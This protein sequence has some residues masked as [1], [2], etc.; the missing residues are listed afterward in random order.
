MDYQ[1]V[2]NHFEKELEISEFLLA[3]TSTT[4][5]TLDFPKEKYIESLNNDIDMY[6]TVVK[7]MK[8]LQ[9]LEAMLK[10]NQEVKA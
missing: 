1:K 6:S 3:Y 5:Y 2:L 9:A 10:N 8:R 4:P 7:A